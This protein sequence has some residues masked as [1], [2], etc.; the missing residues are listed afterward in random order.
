MTEIT[1]RWILS[2]PITKGKP[3]EVE[4]HW[5]L[6]EFGNLD[7]FPGA[8]SHR[9]LS[10]IAPNQRFVIKVVKNQEWWAEFLS[11]WENDEQRIRYFDCKDGTEDALIG[12]KLL[13]KS[14]G[15]EGSLSDTTLSVSYITLPYKAVR[16]QLLALTNT[17]VPTARELVESSVQSDSERKAVLA[18]LDEVAERLDISSRKTRV[19]KSFRNEF[20]AERMGKSIEQLS[21]ALSALTENS[22]LANI[23]ALLEKIDFPSESDPSDNDLLA[24]HIE[25]A[26]CLFQRLD[27]FVRISYRN[28]AQDVLKKSMLANDYEALEKHFFDNILSVYRAS[29]E[30]SRMSDSSAG[31]PYFQ[32]GIHGAVLEALI[33]EE[34]RKSVYPLQVST[35]AVIGSPAKNQID[36]IIWDSQ[37]ASSVV[38]VGEFVFVPASAVCGVLEIKGGVND[39]A[40]V[41]LKLFVVRAIVESLSL[42]EGRTS[43]APPAL[44]IVIADPQT[45]STIRGK[46]V[47]TVISLFQSSTKQELVPNFE[48]YDHY[49]DFLR[50]VLTFFQPQFS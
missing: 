8:T 49:Q 31:T 21:T 26:E 13:S 29:L 6:L 35:G 39:V 14:D 50:S 25:A 5:P 36:A 3:V 43:R 45:S 41:A 1:M 23:G 42:A 38:R 46:S 33:R 40:E 9:S 28:S 47:G 37:R 15:A 10:R 24:A 7:I 18:A 16:E 2:N 48:N 12:L 32:R 27:E 11:S 34:I 19:W 4:L 22:E 30:L 17:T 20:V 44:G